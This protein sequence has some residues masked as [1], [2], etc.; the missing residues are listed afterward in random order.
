M[1]IVAHSP[2]LY[3]GVYTYRMATYISD[4]KTCKLIAEYAELEASRK[5]RLCATFSKPR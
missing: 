4:E 3:I 5:R 1:P 2:A